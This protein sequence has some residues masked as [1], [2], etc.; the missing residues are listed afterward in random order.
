M[1][2]VLKIL[3]LEDNQ[4]DAELIKEQLLADEIKF[5]YMRVETQKDFLSEL[6][7]GKYDLIIADSKLPQFDGRTALEL[8][9][10]LEPDIPFIFVT[11][12]MGEEWAIDTLQQGATDYVLKHRLVRLP[13]TIKRIFNELEDKKRLRV[14]Q[15]AMQM[16]AELLDLAND[17][18][19]IRNSLDAITYWNRGAENMYGWK[20][21]EVLGQNIHNLLK[22]VFPQPLREI[23]QIFHKTGHWE[24]ELI[25]THRD[26]GKIQVISRWT[27]RANRQSRSIE[28][29]EINLDVTESRKLELQFIQAQKMESIG[30]LASGIAH[31]FNNIL[32]IILGCTSFLETDML[33]VEER[34]K[35][36]N[37]IRSGVDRGSSLVKQLLT[38]AR[39][40]QVQ[41]EPISV[42]NS[43]KEFLA[44]LPQ[45]F[46]SSVSF[47]SE[48]AEDLPFI[49]G[50][51]TQVYQILLNLCVNSRDAMPDGGEIT[52]STKKV[53][54][55]EIQDKFP[56]LEFDE[57]V[58]LTVKDSGCG[59]SE[60]TKNRI[61]EPFF[62]TKAIGVGTGL[63]LA[64]VYGIIRAHK[65][66]VDIDTKIGQ[67]TAFHLYFPVVRE[68]YIP[69]T[70]M[71][72]DPE[73]DL[74]GE[75]TI[76][77]V[78]D[79]PML[80]DLLQKFFEQNG[81][82]VL[83]AV[84]GVDAVEVYKKNKDRVDLVLSDIGLPRLS[85]WQA[86]M[87]LKEIDPQVKMVLASG[88]IDPGLKSM[89]FR[90]GV[91]Y[92]VPKPY[93]SREILRSVR[94]ILDQDVM[95]E[96]LLEV[97]E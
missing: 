44:A 96:G 57:H 85:G 92:F 8:V 80:R 81:Y 66:L 75:E 68:D 24:G 34:Q 74:R 12:T 50:D 31:D 51:T 73:E 76:L 82:S 30:T 29:L 61:F 2:S 36:V 10:K 97:L 79:E 43:V 53:S 35:H 65:G 87:K 62:T 32:S 22:T 41:F 9:K 54:A 48:L 64:I 18:I 26:G 58:C 42:N 59:M 89:I 91:K 37:T 88:Y 77:V 93:D 60:E 21:E 67:G 27:A 52:I 70:D 72:Y 13:L 5:E 6:N 95:M 46:P 78:D 39:K 55:K 86:F 16:Q 49:K 1:E 14:A 11:G 15:E 33:P 71:S 40:T 90:A 47:V 56:T 94:K 84:D 69:S 83:T 19:L 63:G 23:Q 28:S 38:F 7:K 17:G 20:R 25:H 45:I 3:H 4:N